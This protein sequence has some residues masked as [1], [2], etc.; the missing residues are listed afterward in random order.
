VLRSSHGRS[1]YRADGARIPNKAAAAA[2][3]EPFNY[4]ETIVG[5]GPFGESKS[6]IFRGGKTSGE[7]TIAA[8]SIRVGN[9]S[10]RR[11]EQTETV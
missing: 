7:R 2:G 9:I 4:R 6:V 1:R 8:R 3:A 5:T 10:R 11:L